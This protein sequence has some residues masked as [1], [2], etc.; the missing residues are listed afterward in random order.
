MCVHTLTKHQE[1]VYSVAFSPDG[2][3]L[4]SGS[5]DKC[6][7]IWNTQVIPA[8]LR[9]G[10][11]TPHLAGRLGGGGAA[12]ACGLRQA[13]S[14]GAWTPTG[15]R[16][17]WWDVRG[18]VA[19]AGSVGWRSFSLLHLWGLPCRRS[20][21]DGA[22]LPGRAPCAPAL[23]QTRVLC[24]T[25]RKPGPQLPRHRRHLRGVLERPRGQSGRQ[26]VRRLCKQHPRFA[27]AGGCGAGRGVTV[28]LAQ[29]QWEGWRSDGEAPTGS[30]RPCAC[31][32][33]LIG[34][35]TRGRCGTS[36]RCHCVSSQRCP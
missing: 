12:G 35:A 31:A 23:F 19:A 24:F 7:H 26:C 32:G 3:Y 33:V 6:V 28:Q 36:S 29:G 22:L 4:A 8:S 16:R 11:A 1:P 9:R 13:R 5:F 17:V 18:P 27:G 34:P 10:Q 2:K 15:C 14:G 25:E 20:G 30:Q 21:A